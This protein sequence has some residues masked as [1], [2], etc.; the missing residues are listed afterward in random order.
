[1]VKVGGFRLLGAFEQD[2]PQSVAE[3]TEVSWRQCRLERY[4]DTIPGGRS[5]S[6]ALLSSRR[7]AVLL[8]A[9]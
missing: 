1:M 2:Y 3:L 7:S 5:E 6:R 9:K 8:M 4:Q